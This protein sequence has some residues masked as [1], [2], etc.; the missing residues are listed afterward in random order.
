MK[1]YLSSEKLGKRGR[2]TKIIKTIPDFYEFEGN[3]YI[4]NKFYKKI[5]FKAK[6]KEDFIR[7]IKSQYQDSL[8]LNG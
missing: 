4:Q 7:K 8:G 3:L 6:D 1:K 5:K 2:L